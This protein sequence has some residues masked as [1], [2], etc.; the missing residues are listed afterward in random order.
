MDQEPELKFLEETHQYFFGGKELPSVT[1][2]MSGIVTDYTRFDKDDVTL[3]CVRGTAV[4]K[5]CELYDKGLLD[6]AS[7]DEALWPYLTAWEKFKSDTRYL[8]A[9]E[10]IEQ[11]VVNKTYRYAGTIDRVGVFINDTYQSIVDIKT[12]QPDHAIG[13]QLA[14]YQL[15]LEKIPTLKKLR[16]RR[17]SVHLTNDGN[18]KM[19]EYVNPQDH[20]VFLACLQI[21]HY[22][23]RKA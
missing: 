7:I 12:G 9:V 23:Q 5:A 21:Y 6:A 2:I 15:A 22:R 3:A 17:F 10:G 14:A 4:H 16:F 13:V 8:F 11:R 18:Y 19:I 20:A 1:K